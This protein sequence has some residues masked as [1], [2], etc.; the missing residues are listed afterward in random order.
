[1]NRGASEHPEEYE[2]ISRLPLSRQNEALR[3]AIGHDPDRIR[4]EQKA[5]RQ[6]PLITCRDC[7]ARNVQNEAAD[8]QRCLICDSPLEDDEC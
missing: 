7:G 2:A 4:D 6:V 1:V 3:D 5:E 8:V